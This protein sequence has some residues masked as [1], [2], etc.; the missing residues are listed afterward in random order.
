MVTES[1]FV[2]VIYPLADPDSRL[3]SW[4]SGLN[5]NTGFQQYSVTDL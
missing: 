2:L 4:V 3:S 5:W 1:V